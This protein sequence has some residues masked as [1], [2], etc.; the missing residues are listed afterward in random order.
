MVVNLFQP[1]RRLALGSPDLDRRLA[2]YRRAQVALRDAL[3]DVGLRDKEILIAEQWLL[4]RE[5]G[6]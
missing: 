6:K 2:E 4:D 5:R 3:H 1:L